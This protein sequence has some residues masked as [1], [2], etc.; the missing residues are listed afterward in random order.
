MLASAEGPFSSDYSIW[1]SET[2]TGRVIKKLAGHSGSVTGL[3]FA[4][5][6]RHLV[7]VSNDQTGLV[8]DVTLPALAVKAVDKRLAEAWDRL[9]ALDPGLGYVGMAA[10]AAAPAEALPLLRAKLRPAPVPTEVD[11]DRLIGQLEADPFAEREKASAELEQFGA[12]AVAG[13][14]DRLS[15]VASEEVRKRLTRFLERYDGPDPSPYQ[16]SCVRGVNV[17]EIIGTAEARQVLADLAKGAVDA[18]L[19]REARLSLDRLA[20]RSR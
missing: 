18:P 16:V 13:V 7:S 12:N 11:L 17:L 10:L 1:V 19:T 6:G 4:P 15:R 2:V 9:A 14:K 5:N 3:A 8:W 20:Q